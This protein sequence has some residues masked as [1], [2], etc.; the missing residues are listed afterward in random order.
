MSEVTQKLQRMLAQAQ[1]FSQ[2]TPR[3]A[4]ARAELAVQEADSALTTAQ[5]TEREQL[6]T[7]RAMAAARV[8][9]Y[10]AQLANWTRGVQQ[11]ADLFESNEQDRLKQPI[12]SS[13]V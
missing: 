1:G 3:E 5:G 7:L 12:P 8:E 10:G 2:D 9:N 6:L 4:V 11:R 13:K